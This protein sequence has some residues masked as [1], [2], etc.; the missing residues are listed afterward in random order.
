VEATNE[1]EKRA[2]GRPWARKSSGKYPFDFVFKVGDNGESLKEQLNVLFA[3][4]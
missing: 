2:V 3:K 4:R 1:I